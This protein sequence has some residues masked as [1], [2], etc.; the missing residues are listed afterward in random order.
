MY[1]LVLSGLL[2][3]SS[4]SYAQNKKSLDSVDK[5]IINQI[6]TPAEQHDPGQE[7]QWTA[8]TQQIKA[9]YS[10]VQADRAITKGQIYFYYG[11]NW[12]K[13]CA[14]LVHYTE[15]YE[16]KND[17]A[18]MNKNANFILDRSTDPKE[19]ATALGWIK[20]AVD[21]EPSNEKYKTIYDALA[22]KV[23]VQ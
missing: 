16:D 5:I 2:L 14:A 23:N 20:H 1:K 7:P 19:L 21:K 3:V 9:S 12:P 15:A 8:L 17:L 4:L 18:L 22:A 13:F 6:I 10:D 11:K